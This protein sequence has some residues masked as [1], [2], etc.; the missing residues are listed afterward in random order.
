LGCRDGGEV[1]LTV[2]SGGGHNWPG[3]AFFQQFNDPASP[4]HAIT[5]TST[6]EVDATALIWAFFRD[7]ALGG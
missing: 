7:H 5:G 6:D 1:R 4:M 2:I 3:S